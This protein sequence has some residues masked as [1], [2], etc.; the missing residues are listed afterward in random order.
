MVTLSNRVHFFARPDVREKLTE[1]FNALL[2]CDVAAVPGTSILLV[3]FPNTNLT[4]DFT[5]DAPDEQ[6]AR[7]GA[8]LELKA[9]DPAALKL[10]V[11]A[12]GLPL[13]SYPT[14]RFYFQ[15]PGGQ[16]WGIAES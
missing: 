16:V 4:V 8:W 11:L 12:A 10:K 3:R 2:G 14:G 5:D 6:Q 7:R 13:V 9:D 15:S 1:F